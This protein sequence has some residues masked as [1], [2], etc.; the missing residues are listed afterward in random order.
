M[1]VTVLAPGALPPHKFGTRDLH[2]LLCMS[3]Y[4]SDRGRYFEVDVHCFLHEI[5]WNFGSLLFWLIGN[6]AKALFPGHSFISSP[7][8]WG[9]PRNEATKTVKSTVAASGPLLLIK[10]WRWMKV[11]NN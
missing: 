2:L 5:L 1:Y 3:K 7:V 6:Y 10:I 4:V 8:V 11:N 9:W